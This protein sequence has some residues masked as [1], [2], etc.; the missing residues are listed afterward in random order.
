MNINKNINT[1]RKY[2]ETICTV[3]PGIELKGTPCA[4]CS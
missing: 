2:M 1:R 3:K 4:K